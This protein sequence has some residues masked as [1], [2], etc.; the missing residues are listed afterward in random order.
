MTCA[1]TIK[2]QCWTAA[3]Q[4]KEAGH[5]EPVFAL[6]AYSN[7]QLQVYEVC[8]VCGKSLNGPL[9]KKDHPD[10][11]FYPRIDQSGPLSWLG[12]CRC[13]GC[14]KDWGEKEVQLQDQGRRAKWREENAGPWAQTGQ[15][16]KDER[17][18]RMPTWGEYQAY[19]GS[20][21]WQDVRRLVIASFDGRCATC[22]ASD[23]LEVHHRT[24]ERVGD[25]RMDDLTLLCSQCHELLHSTWSALAI[26][27]GYEGPP[28]R[29]AA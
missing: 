28:I 8:S 15:R 27:P 22:N 23:A 25:E 1:A 3:R 4:C 9:K 16:L 2:Q 24:Y 18:R 19:L 11:S 12:G 7:G 26:T 17:E 14:L 13:P 5:G 20:S 6:R 10:Q 29:R 21:A